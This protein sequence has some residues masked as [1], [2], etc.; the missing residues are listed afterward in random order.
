[1]IEIKNITGS[2]IDIVYDTNTDS[3]TIIPNIQLDVE[4]VVSL[5]YRQ[6][7]ANVINLILT[8]DIEIYQDEEF[9]D[10]EGHTLLTNRYDKIFNK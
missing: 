5:E 8:G 2:N 10:K 7:L 1:M 6:G 4:N 3:E 9:K